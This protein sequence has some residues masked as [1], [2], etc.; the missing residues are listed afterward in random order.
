M[1]IG[2]N[3]AFKKDDQFAFKKKP[4]STGSNIAPILIFPF[5]PLPIVKQSTV[6]LSAEPEVWKTLVPVYQEQ[7]APGVW[8]Y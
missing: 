7:N 2:K 1:I 3:Y 5:F 6:I 4:A 8:N